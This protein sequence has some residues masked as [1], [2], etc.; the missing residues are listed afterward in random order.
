MRAA[1]AVLSLLAADPVLA[2]PPAAP[3]RAGEVSSQRPPALR[4]PGIARAALWT[5][6]RDRFVTSS[7][8]VIDDA[9]G[10]ISHSEGQGYAMLLAASF[11]D[12]ATF[13]RIWTWTR[14][15]LCIRPDGLAAWRWRPSHEPHVDDLNNATDG[16]L[17]I[18]WALAEAGRRWNDEGYTQAAQGMARTIAT[19]MTA[20][21]VLGT[22]LLPGGA[23]F[24]AQ[25][26]PDG[27][28]VNPSYWVFPAFDAL[29]PLVPEVDW[30]GLRA[31]GLALLREARFGPLRLPTDW[32]SLRNTPARPA[33]GFP[34]EFSYNA[35]RIPLYLAWAEGVTAASIAPFA[36]LWSEEGDV[37]PFVIEVRTGSAQSTFGGRGFKTVAA[38]ARCVKEGRKIPAQLVEPAPKDP[39][40]PSTLQLLAVVLADERYPSCV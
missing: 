8:R 33:D 5:T 18:A 27:P 22:V 9:N 37:G 39:Y 7:G 21:T 3:T 15:E 19:T 13:E 17:L 11:D 1:L 28:V 23:G 30:S 24:S 20:Q 38:L 31:S 29:R 2:G 6:Y 34:A 32:V 35:I 12:R 26:R 4:P 10:F 14:R 36:R 40:Y 25:D 16:D